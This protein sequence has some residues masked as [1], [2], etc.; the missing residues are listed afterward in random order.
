MSRAVPLATLAL[1]SSLAGGCASET[2]SVDEE[3]LD[4]VDDGDA[5]SAANMS[6]Y[7]NSSGF[8]PVYYGS[9]TYLYYANNQDMRGI[10]YGKL[11]TGCYS[12]RAPLTLVK[13]SLGK[14]AFPE[15]VVSMPRPLWDRANGVYL[16][17]QCKR[18]VKISYDGQTTYAR[19]VDR[20]DKNNRWEFSS[21][22]FEALGAEYKETVWDVARDRVSQYGAG[23]LSGA[24]VELMAAD[25]TP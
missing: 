16:N 19:V 1:V 13:N 5:L 25:F 15:P 3:M 11:M 23:D 8:K 14:L 4:A 17:T 9:P 18:Y 21:E 22:V 12:Q 7:P 24:V 20:S 2:E 10:G 6:A